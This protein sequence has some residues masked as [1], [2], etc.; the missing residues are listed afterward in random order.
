MTGP[1]E[2]TSAATGRKLRAG[3]ARVFPLK[4]NLASR[5]LLPSYTREL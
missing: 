1:A 3:M 4:D 5:G 2:E